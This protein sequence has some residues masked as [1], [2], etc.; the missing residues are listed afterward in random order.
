MAGFDLTTEAGESEILDP[1]LQL[2]KSIRREPV[3]SCKLRY[4][5]PFEFF[6]HTR[7]KPS[8]GDEAR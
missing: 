4:F 6:D 7:S 2:E 8:H 1:V 5:N 3:E